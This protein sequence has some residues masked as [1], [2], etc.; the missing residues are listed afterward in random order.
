MPVGGTGSATIKIADAGSFT[1]GV[2]LAVTSTLPSGV[3]ASFASNPATA[4]DVLTFSVD[5]SV[6][7]QDTP[8]TVTGTSGSLTQSANLT[9]SI[10]APTF[11]L[12]PSSSGFTL[13]PGGTTVATITVV[14]EYGFSGCVILAIAGLESGVTGSFSPTT[15]T[16]TSSLSL[17]AS[18]SALGGTNTLTITGTSG[19]I[20]AMDNGRAAIGPRSILRAV[21]GPR[22]LQSARELQRSTYVAK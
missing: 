13:N 10:H 4:S 21:C 19:A 15:T 14:P 8:V 17:A 9:L 22:P 3:S 5:S 11:A 12:T 18:Y 7:Q 1:G 16:G 2:N 6:A 20:T